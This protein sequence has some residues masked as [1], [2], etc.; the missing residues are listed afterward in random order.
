MQSNSDFFDLDLEGL[1]IFNTTAFQGTPQMA[2]DK[3]AIR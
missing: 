1:T 3:E 2:A